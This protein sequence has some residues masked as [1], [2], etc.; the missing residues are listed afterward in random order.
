[1]NPAIFESDE[2]HVR[3]LIPAHCQISDCRAFRPLLVSTSLGFDLTGLEQTAIERL[4]ILSYGKEFLI[5]EIRQ[6]DEEGISLKQ[7]ERRV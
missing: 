3:P 2:M 5:R 1:M 6:G 4:M 7:S